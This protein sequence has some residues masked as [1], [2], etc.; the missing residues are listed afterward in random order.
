MVF[1]LFL[2]WFFQIQILIQF[3]WIFITRV[4]Y[5]ICYPVSFSYAVY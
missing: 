4:L 2:I 5:R 3:V 1:I